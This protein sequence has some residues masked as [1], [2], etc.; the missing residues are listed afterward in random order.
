MMM[1]R[2]IGALAVVLV[3]G[4]PTASAQ[5]P[6]TAARE[7]YASAAYEEALDVIAGLRSAAPAVANPEGE[8]LRAFC[9]LALQ[10]E[11][12]ARGVIEDVITERPL[13]LPS[14]DEASPKVRSAF[15]DVR[16]ELLPSI[17]RQLYDAAR[18]NYARKEHVTAAA[19][20]G[21]LLRVLDDPDVASDETLADLRLLAEGFREVSAAASAAVAT[22]AMASLPPVAP[23]EE[24]SVPV[25][26]AVLTPPVIVSQQLPPWRAPSIG[27]RIEYSGA[28]DLVINEEGRLK[29]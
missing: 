8:V 29:A 16:R 2:L 7:L 13:Y 11:N 12:E 4:A 26:P 10:R 21:D 6:L 20:F 9:L 19:Q 22:A 3:W 15:R 1:I 14:D 28:I 24:P 17:A 18:E 5:E 27:P 23:A 25:V